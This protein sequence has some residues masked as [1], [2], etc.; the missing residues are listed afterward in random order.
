MDYPISFR[1]EMMK[2]PNQ[3]PRNI[4][5]PTSHRILFIVEVF[6]DP[7]TNGVFKQSREKI[8]H[9]VCDI[10]YDQS[11]WYNVRNVVFLVLPLDITQKAIA[12]NIC[13]DNFP[14]RDLILRAYHDGRYIRLHIGSFD[15]YQSFPYFSQSN[16]YSRM[17]DAN[18]LSMAHLVDKW[19]FIHP[20]RW[21][22]GSQVSGLSL[23]DYRRYVINHEVGHTLGFLHFPRENVVQGQ[24]GS[25][26]LQ[27]TRGQENGQFGSLPNSRPSQGID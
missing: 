11:G 10:L 17:N 25:I 15:Y 4:D 9:N 26:M 19:I 6:I 5:A 20:K 16:I 21:S 22:E 18:E 8:Y 1:E 14:N 7:N 24:L 2:Y 23:D 13:P 27:H 12:Q 3:P